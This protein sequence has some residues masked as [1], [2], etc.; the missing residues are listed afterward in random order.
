M[1]KSLSRFWREEFTKVMELDKFDKQY[2]YNIRYNYG[3]EG[4]QTNWTPYSCMKIISGN[5]GI[6][7]THGCPFKTLDTTGLK[8]KLTTY[9]FSTAHA[10]EV[11]AY[12]S[13][14]HYQLACGKY[15]EVMHENRIEEGISHPNGFFEKSQAVIEGRQ[16][17]KP[18][19]L[20][21]TKT[22]NPNS[23]QKD[24]ILK[25]AKQTLLDEY[26]DE[27]WNATQQAELSETSRRDKI[28]WD[29]DMDDEDFS[30]MEDMF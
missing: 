24:V 26:D 27:L 8:S 20:N 22:N 1:E 10:Q 7:E 6:G 19:N 2:A 21:K 5:V 28:A 16:D 11:A 4:S 15:F 3:K 29:N 30:Q 23:N 17:A 14:Q 25:R 12:A 13:K 9:G 18:A